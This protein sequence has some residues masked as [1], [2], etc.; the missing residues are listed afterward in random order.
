MS[1]S[2]FCSQ[3]LKGSDDYAPR[4]GLCAHHNNSLLALIDTLTGVACQGFGGCSRCRVAAAS[5]TVFALKRRPLP[6]PTDSSATVAHAT[7]R[8]L[9]R[10]IFQEHS[11]PQPSPLQHP[12]EFAEFVSTK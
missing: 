10:A 11:L 8:L 6:S 1:F 4:R 5:A 9:L 12:G 3:W 2:S 7:K